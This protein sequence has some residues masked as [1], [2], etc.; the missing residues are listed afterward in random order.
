MSKKT[1]ADV[2]KGDVIELGG[3]EWS[4]VKIK[5]KGKKA[6][7][8]VSHKSRT[9]SSSVKLA[10][11]VTIVK[12]RKDADPLRDRDGAQRRWAKPSEVEK[13]APNGASAGLKPGKAKQTKPPEAATGSPWETPADRIE[14]KLDEILGARLIAETGN[15]KLGYYVPPVDITTI[16]AHLAVFH[17]GIPEAVDDDEAKMLAVHRAQHDAALKGAALAINHWHTEKRPGLTS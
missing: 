15:E 7:V 1:W 4:V 13:A 12:R 11:K 17:G 16:A 9:A 3:R 8:D 14:K 5:A 10:D 6:T 2:K